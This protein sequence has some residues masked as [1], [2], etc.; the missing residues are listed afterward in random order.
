MNDLIQP[1]TL[2]RQLNT[3]QIF[4]VGAKTAQ[5]IHAE[6]ASA[7]YKHA[8]IPTAQY[9]DLNQDF[10]NLRTALEYQYPNKTEMLDSLKKFQVDWQK[11]IVIYDRENH[12]WA[13]RLFWILK[14]FGHPQV[15][16]LHGGFRA[17]QQQNLSVS[18]QIKKPIASFNVAAL[19][20]HSTYFADINDVKDVVAGYSNAQLLNVLRAEVFRGDELR[21]SRAGHIPKSINIPFA[22]FLDENGK[23]K[24]SIFNFVA[25]FGLDL[26]REIIVY[27]GSGITASGAALAL[28]QAQ[29]TSIKIYDG[30]MSE[31][32]ADP[33]LPLQI[34]V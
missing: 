11:P 1:E 13:A 19:T 4:E 2:L 14:A 25:Q 33:D 16:V 3:V 30:S 21:Y 34:M 9:V 23:F 29:A 18:D 20:F 12:I 24:A 17:W 7:L 6:Q 8:H 26:N 31:W 5:P 15:Q 10:C 28:R 22:K 32:S 27:C